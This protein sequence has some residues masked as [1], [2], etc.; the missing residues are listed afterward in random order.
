MKNINFKKAVL[1]LFLLF[2]TMLSYGQEGY[3]EVVYLKNGSV[4]RGV[5]IEQIP[6][7]SIKIETADRN[8][9]VY[10][11]EEIEKITKE[12]IPEQ[13][14]NNKKPVNQ[15]RGLSAGYKGIVDIGYDIGVGDY[16]VDRIRLNIINGYQ[17]NPYF[18]MGFGLGVRYY[19]DAEAALM[20]FFADF[21]AN[22]IDNS[23]SPYFSLGFGYS[24]DLTDY[25][26]GVGILLNPTIGVSFKVSDKTA[27]NIGVG[28]E[29]Q[30]MKYYDYYNGSSSLNSG[31]IGFN[32]GVSF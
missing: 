10:K 5:I 17:F 11:M 32:F 20:P 29:M 28:Y 9:F 13:F 16:G 1:I 3:E 6:N 7:V 23:V 12:R 19:Y 14:R 24:F 26:E 31:A 4:I 22:F 30:R 27:L 15:G 8:I 18:S 25:F 21:R 2:G